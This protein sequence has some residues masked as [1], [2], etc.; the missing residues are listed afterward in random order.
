ML[1]ERLFHAL[2]DVSTDGHVRLTLCHSEQ[3]IIDG[4]GLVVKHL[5]E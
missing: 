3:Y 1:Q 4:S 2:P 5:D